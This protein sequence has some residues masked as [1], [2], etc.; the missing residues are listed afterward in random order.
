MRT[1]SLAVALAALLAGCSSAQIYN[2]AAG[3]RR[4]ECNRIG[5]AQQRE[6]CLKEE[7]DRS[8]DA[9]RKALPPPQ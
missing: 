1:L 4:N 6:R 9:Y 5:D 3:W 2:A 8:Y 7:A